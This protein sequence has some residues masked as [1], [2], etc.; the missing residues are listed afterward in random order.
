LV[1][2]DQLRFAGD[3]VVSPI[4]QHGVDTE[5]MRRMVAVA[6]RAMNEGTTWRVSTHRWG[7]ITD[8]AQALDKGLLPIASVRRGNE[9]HT[10]VVFSLRVGAIRYFDPRTDL[11]PWVSM[12]DFRKEWKDQDGHTWFAL[13]T[14]TTHLV[15]RPD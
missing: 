10:V 15:N 3:D 9:L 1:S 13:I 7:S 11:R 12:R 2:E 4:M 14:G 5:T 6:D 8:M